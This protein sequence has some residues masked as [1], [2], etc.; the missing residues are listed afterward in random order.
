MVYR[1]QTVLVA[2]CQV[3]VRLR[4]REAKSVHVRPSGQR[5]H[6]PFIGHV[7]LARRGVVATN[8]PREQLNGTH[9]ST[10]LLTLLEDAEQVADSPV[11]ALAGAT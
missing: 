9:A 7:C 10:L 5:V 8:Q 3:Y 6:S 4:H 2:A 1:Q 11:K